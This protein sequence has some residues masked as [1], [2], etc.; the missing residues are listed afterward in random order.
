MYIILLCI[1][2]IV[3]EPE[4]EPEPPVPA[5]SR[6]GTGGSKNTGFLSTLVIADFIWMAG[7]GILVFT[8]QLESICNHPLG[9]GS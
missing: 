4:S 6:T 9:H 2:N 8:K 1:Y 5:D 7:Q 3:L